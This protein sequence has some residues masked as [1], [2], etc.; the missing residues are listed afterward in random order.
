[1][2]REIRYYNA[3]TWAQRR[4]KAMPGV[5][6]TA[7]IGNERLSCTADEDGRTTWCTWQYFPKEPL[8]GHH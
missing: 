4:A 8:N 2:K 7:A 1:M 3:K 5:T 6:M